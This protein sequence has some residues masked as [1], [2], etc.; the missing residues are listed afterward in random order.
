[1][2]ILLF[3]GALVPVV[4]PTPPPPPTGFGHGRP[5]FDPFPHRRPGEHS[6]GGFIF[7]DEDGAGTP[8][9]TGPGARFGTDGPDRRMA[10]PSSGGGTPDATK[11]VAP[12]MT[13][14]SGAAGLS[15]R[16]RKATI[17]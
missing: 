13:G 10:T 14:P 16:G 8:G 2:L 5:D 12:G 7:P 11:E 6:P 17:H 15:R 9:V 4:A 1:M 3:N